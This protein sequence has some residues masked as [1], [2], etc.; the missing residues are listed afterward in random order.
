MS[1]TR[2]ALPPQ[3]PRTPSE[4]T[5]P[6]RRLRTALATVLGALLP[7]LAALFAGAPSAQAA[8][9]VQINNFGNN[10]T[11]L[12]MHLY[13]PDQVQDP[14]PVLLAVHYCTGSGPAFYSGTEFARLADQHG[15]IVIYPSATR[16]GQCFDVS[17][18]QALRRD[19]GSDPVGLRSM[20]SYV[21]QNH[22]VDPE[23]IF[24]TGASSGA[25]MTNVMLG[26]YPDVFAAG[27]SFAGVP[28]GCFGTTDGSSWNSQCSSGQ[29]VHSAQQWGDMVRSAY[30]GYSGERPRV[31][32]W[33]GTND[34]T[35]HYNN[36]NEAIK[37]WTNVHGL[38]QTP[39]FSDQPNGWNRTRYGGTG[40]QATIEAISLPN[41]GHNL[42]MGGQAAEAIR[43]FGLDQPTGEDPGEDPGEEPGQQPGEGVRVMPLGDSITDGF[44]VP[45]GY[46][47]DLWQDFQA[48]G[49]DVDFVG[50]MVNGPSSLGDRDHEGHSG[51]TIQQ[52]DQNITNWL[53]THDPDTILLHIG[54]NDIYGSDPNGAP[55]RLATLVDR[56]TAQAPDTHL[57]VSTITPLGFFNDRVQAFNSQVPGIVNAA[58]AEG[59]NVH[60]VDNYSALTTADLA[61]GVHPNATGYSK[62]ADVWYEAL[63]S[64]PGAL[65]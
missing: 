21:E 11:N 22:A 32:L 16:S 41:V 20:I 30:P 36:F 59:A 9:L 65:G 42:P 54:T 25:M 60:L 49:H 28:F 39:D 62:M 7:L 4:P 37:Q 27:A 58:A 48:G 56:I 29:R 14:A 52:I 57:F 23:R 24:V 61:D 12:S 51:W 44:N 55:A 6:A 1:T 43:F 5:R 19:G 50:S 46:R 26:L 35:L 17:S 40:G 53:T 10:P 3:P 34:T 18:P 15:F 13:V 33:H 64:V 8:Q 63:L 31:Q 45:G 47:V 2:A 38:S